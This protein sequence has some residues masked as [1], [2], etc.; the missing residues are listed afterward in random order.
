MCEVFSSVLGVE[1]V[2]SQTWLVNEFYLRWFHCSR[3]LLHFVAEWIAVN[4]CVNS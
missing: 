4:Q 1:A 2:L 3:W